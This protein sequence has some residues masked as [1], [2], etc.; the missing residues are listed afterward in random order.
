MSLNFCFEQHKAIYQ[1]RTQETGCLLPCYERTV[2]N[3]LSAHNAAW[4]HNCRCKEHVVRKDLSARFARTRCWH[5][6][7]SSR[8]TRFQPQELRKSTSH[9]LYT[10]KRP[11][12][13]IAGLRRAQCAAD[14]GQLLF[15]KLAYTGIR[16]YESDHWWQPY[17]CAADS[18]N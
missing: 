16:N 14:S 13:H 3:L 7:D 6:Q 8:F 4:Q 18:M 10:C 5:L 17:S 12:S 15:G 11:F 2:E 9:F 1:C